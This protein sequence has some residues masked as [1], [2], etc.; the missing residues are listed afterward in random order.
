MNFTYLLF[1][2]VY[3]NELLHFYIPNNILTEYDHKQL[4]LASDPIS[5]K[6]SKDIIFNNMKLWCQYKRSGPQHNIKITDTYC[7]S[8]M[9]E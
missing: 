2:N 4:N 3:E 6:T 5:D 8:I 7:V 9:N 1:A